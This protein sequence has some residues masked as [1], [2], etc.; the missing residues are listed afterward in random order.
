MYMLEIPILRN[1]LQNILG[2]LR[3]DFKGSGVEM[4]AQKSWWLRLTLQIL[5]ISHK[6]VSSWSGIKEGCFSNLKQGEILL[7]KHFLK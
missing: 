1:S 2:V 6:K 5:E 3:G 4:D 7:V